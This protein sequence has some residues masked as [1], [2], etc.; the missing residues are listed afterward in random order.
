[1][2][3]RCRSDLHSD[4]LTRWWMDR[5]SHL[6]MDHG[7]RLSMA[8]SHCLSRSLIRCQSRSAN[9]YQIRWWNGWST[10][11]RCSFHFR[12]NLA[13]R[14]WIGFLNH[15]CSM[16]RFLIAIHY[17]IRFPT[18]CPTRFA[19]RS[20]F[21]WIDSPRRTRCHWS[22]W[23]PSSSATSNS[24]PICYRCLDLGSPI[25]FPTGSRFPN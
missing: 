23:A 25:G 7:N 6:S 3:V 20:R 13:D 18:G 1:L 16:A 4:D 21:G 11:E 12:C 19:I 24:V 22:N 17:L 5:V 2:A 15:R 10:R 8:M 9:S 14:C